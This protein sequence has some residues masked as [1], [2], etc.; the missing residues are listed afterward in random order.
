MVPSRRRLPHSISLQR[1]TEPVMPITVGEWNIISRTIAPLIYLPSLGTG[2]SEITED[3]LFSGSHFGLGE[4]MTGKGL[5]PG[6]TAPQTRAGLAAI[7]CAACG[8]KASAWS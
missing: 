4:P 6:L 8:S 5:S 1:G 3:S 2:P 7:R